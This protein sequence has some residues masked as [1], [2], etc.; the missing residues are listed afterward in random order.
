MNFKTKSRK[1]KQNKTNG[2]KNEIQAFL[3]DPRISFWSSLSDDP[4]G[5]FHPKMLWLRPFL[6]SLDHAG[7]EWLMSPP[8]PT[9]F[10]SLWGS[11][12]SCTCKLFRILIG[13]IWLAKQR[14]FICE[15]GGDPEQGTVLNS[16]VKKKQLPYAAPT[17]IQV[18]RS[19]QFLISPLKSHHSHIPREI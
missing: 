5:P 7:L 18:I 17:W 1:Q 6:P 10:P 16:V 14:K 15:L 11:S 19:A 8:S 12:Y 3:E 9:T 4:I 13:W 2:M